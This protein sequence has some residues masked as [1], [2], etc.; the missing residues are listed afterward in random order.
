[1]PQLTT[2]RTDAAL[3]V[4]AWRERKP[5]DGVVHVR[6]VVFRGRQRLQ[7]AIVVDEKTFYFVGQ[8]VKELFEPE[9]MDKL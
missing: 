9:A 8:Q 3:V 4:E 6:N 5:D 2:T 1:M 7:M